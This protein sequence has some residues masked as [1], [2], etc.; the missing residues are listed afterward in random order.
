MTGASKLVLEDIVALRELYEQG[1]TNAQI[2]RTFTSLSGKS[3]SREHVSRI[4]SGK[5]WNPDNHSFLV[6]D[7]LPI[8]QE[9]TTQIMKDTYTT[10]L[11]VV[12]TKS[13]IYHIF[14]CY[15]NDQ[16]MEGTDTPLIK[17]KPSNE[18]MLEYH[19]KWVWNEISKI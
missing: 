19:N 3:V 17:D 14:M 15:T 4:R 10:E 6:K 2:A 16:F 11:S 7:H 1:L 5:R 18:E 13:G 8:N 12:V 9:I